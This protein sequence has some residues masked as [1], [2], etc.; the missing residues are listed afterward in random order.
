MVGG[1]PSPTLSIMPPPDSIP[2]SQRPTR[3]W[4]GGGAGGVMLR[5]PVMIQLPD[6]EQ[7][8]RTCGRVRG[9]TGVLGESMGSRL[10]LSTDQGP[11]RDKCDELPLVTASR[12]AVGPACPL[13][14]PHPECGAGRVGP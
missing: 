5:L 7:S 14:N 11:R 4:R 3:G 1:S 13:P 10:G 9:L 12:K 8:L 6:P 2:R